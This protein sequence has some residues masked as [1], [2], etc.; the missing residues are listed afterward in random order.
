MVLFAFSGR[1]AGEEQSFFLGAENGPGGPVYFGLEGSASGAVGP[2]RYAYSG[3]VRLGNLLLASG[4]AWAG[5]APLP[6]LQLRAG[7][8]AWFL[9]PGRTGRS[10]GGR[11]DWNP[12]GPLTFSFA[13]TPTAWGAALKLGDAN[14]WAQLWLRK[15]DWLAAA[16]LGYGRLAFTGWYRVAYA[17]AASSRYGVRAAWRIAPAA[18]S[19]GYD[20]RWGYEAGF[21]WDSQVYATARV[22]WRPGRVGVANARLSFP[23]DEGVVVAS[24][25]AFSW[26]PF[27]GLHAGLELRIS[28]YE[29]PP[30]QGE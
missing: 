13:A 16:N 10:A 19:L 26:Q 11:V 2:W 27:Y 7:Y 30:F 6:G 8:D 21:E 25:A 3:R 9:Q 17:P 24:S 4:Y 18:F 1:A 22:R 20:S 28:P 23:I 29:A 15:E 12:A 5:V 14:N